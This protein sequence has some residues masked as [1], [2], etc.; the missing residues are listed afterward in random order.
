MVWKG[1]ERSF[2]G[3]WADNTVARSPAAMGSGVEATSGGEEGGTPKRMKKVVVG[4][5]AHYA[6]LDKGE[7]REERGREQA[8][9]RAEEGCKGR[10]E[11]GCR[12]FFI[13]RVGERIRAQGAIH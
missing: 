4:V 12:L 8:R 11:R 10:E 2:G 3:R 7:E 6:D 1:G 13:F 9:W 5:G